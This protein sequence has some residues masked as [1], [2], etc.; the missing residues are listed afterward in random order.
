MELNA[1]FNER[2]LIHAD[3]L[4]W[5]DSPVA[6]V[7]RRM[8]DRIGDEIARA[9]TIVSFAPDSRFSA[10]VHGGGE[11][12]LVL[13]GVFEDEHGSFPVGTYVRNPPTSRHTP[14]ST[15]GCIL[16]VKLWQF[17]PGDRTHIIQNTNS[18]AAIDDLHRPGVS[19]IPLFRDNRENVRI[20]MLAP[21]VSAAIDT[22][23]GAEILV[24]TGQC[25]QNGD[26][27]VRHTWLRVP[28]GARTVLTTAD[29]PM[30]AWIKSGHLQYARPP[31]A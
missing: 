6:G 20:E 27:L 5:K 24:L 11:E 25:Q 3:Q 30:R 23:G 2:V 18:V 29:Q 15:P 21:N 10:H 9:T 17:D 16:F 28:D 12:F 31:Q 22:A 1:N 4:A 26:T 8:L 14:G 13:E 19:V 7:R